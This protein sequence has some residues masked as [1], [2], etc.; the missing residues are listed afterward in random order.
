MNG[1]TN[2]RVVSDLLGHAQAS[3]TLATYFPDED[4]AADAVAKAEK[5]L[6]CA[7]QTTMARA[8]LQ[9]C[10]PQ[11]EG[12]RSPRFLPILKGNDPGPSGLWLT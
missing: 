9:G 8:L 6:G 12:F 2:P 4:A 10:L 3:F 11:R 5:A 7:L 1:D